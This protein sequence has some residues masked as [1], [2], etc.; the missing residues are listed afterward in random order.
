M[1]RTYEAP[2]LERGTPAPTPERP[3]RKV[4]SGSTSVA[5]RPPDPEPPTPTPEGNE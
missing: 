4:I 3:A 5:P 2:K 1:K